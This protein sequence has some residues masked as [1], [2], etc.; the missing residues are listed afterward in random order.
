MAFDPNKYGLTPADTQFDPNKYGLTPVNNEPVYQ[1]SNLEDIFRGVGQGVT[2]G[3][4]DELMG[5][6]ENPI[7]AG[8]DILNLVGANI[9]DED[10]AEYERMRDLQRRYNEASKERSPWLYGGGELAGG[11][12]TA[13]ATAPLMPIRAAGVVAKVAP[14]AAGLAAKIAPEG[15]NILLKG[16]GYTVGKLAPAAVGA[17]AEG[18]VYGAGMGAGYSNDA[19]NIGKDI[20]SGTAQGAAFGS[21]LGALG[22]AGGDALEFLKGEDNA[23]LRQATSN[24]FRRAYN[25]E[26][27][28]FSGDKAFDT[29]V[30]EMGRTESIPLKETMEDILGKTRESFKNYI[31]E[32]TQ[33]GHNFDVNDLGVD[34]LLESM[35]KIETLRPGYIEKSPVFN[36][37]TQSLINGERL[38]PKQLQEIKMVFRDIGKQWSETTADPTGTFKDA[39][40]GLKEVSDRADGLLST[41]DGYK[42]LNEFYSKPRHSIG[43]DDYNLTPDKKQELHNVLDNIYMES[44]NPSGGHEVT[45]AKNDLFK[46]LED[47]QSDPVYG[48]LIDESLQSG[49]AKL[50]RM[51][52]VSNIKNPIHAFKEHIK[53]VSDKFQEAVRGRGSVQRSGSI[54]AA[55]NIAATGSNVPLRGLQ[56]TADLAGSLARAG[57]ETI[58]WVNLPAHL[59]ERA[60]LK[61]Q[62]IPKF[63][64][65]GDALLKASMENDSQAKNAVI[66]TLMQKPETRN[67]LEDDNFLQ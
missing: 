58:N 30:A 56:H 41:L 28:D 27:F 57:K 14:R 59:T 20:A 42:E 19:G 13:I 17:A 37:L 12:G 44:E 65:Y 29:Y 67:L 63:K 50:E 18:A 52:G 48:N 33:G 66:F 6:I 21:V 23:G 32:V 26:K 35:H 49:L 10:V 46:A 64:S 60:A 36:E 40:R 25:G 2:I 53:Q 38:T 16:A 4:S 1:G 51:N 3:L 62:S 54:R 24:A 34:E 31:E 45:R 47:M 22:K 5:A 9:K 11:L 8:K 15:S 7:G 39:A 43:I 61:L 55:S